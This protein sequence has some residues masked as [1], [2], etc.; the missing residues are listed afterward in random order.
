MK[1]LISNI[2]MATTDKVKFEL[3]QAELNN[4]RY[5]DK[6][7]RLKSTPKNET[8]SNRKRSVNS[9]TSS[10]LV[11]TFFFC[12][13]AVPVRRSKSFLNKHNNVAGGISITV[14]SR[15]LL[16]VARLSPV[17]IIYCF[18]TPVPVLVPAR[19]FHRRKNYRMEL[20]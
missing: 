7:R 15:D 1:N 4:L 9:V 6:L 19:N 11:V 10:H 20:V 18:N 16:F 3:T 14:C 17:Q 13:S 8:N 5:S 2:Q 12:R